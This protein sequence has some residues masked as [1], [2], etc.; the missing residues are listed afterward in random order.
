[1]N[2]NYVIAALILTFI[3]ITGMLK[4]AKAK[5]EIQKYETLYKNDN[6][7]IRYY[8][9][10]ILASVD[11][12]GN[13]D[14]TRNS[15]FSILAGYIFGGNK[16]KSKI[17][18]TSPVRMSS[19]EKS[20]RMSFVLPSEMEFGNLPEPNDSRIILHKSD[21]VYAAVIRYGGY[22]NSREINQK[23]KEL[24]AMLEKMGISFENDF[25]YLGYNAPFDMLNR[26][27]EVLVEL[28]DFNPNA[29]QQIIAEQE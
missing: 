22:T 17:A 19:N 8:P 6:F 12:D 27:N 9:Q 20:N 28:K 24:S 5:T 18:M 23:K 4:M 21:S 14:N 26:R 1:M 29:L 13:Y 2:N 7:E 10:A 11:L 16:E 25:E 15:G 3:A